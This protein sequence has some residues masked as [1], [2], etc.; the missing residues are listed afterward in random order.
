MDVHNSMLEKGEWGSIE[1]ALDARCA[2]WL[3]SCMHAC[4]VCHTGCS[5]LMCFIAS[6][7]FTQNG[8]NVL[9]CLTAASSVQLVHGRLRANSAEF[10]EVLTLLICSLQ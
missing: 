4:M 3:R 2:S 9:S 8:M 5:S 6:E 10:H 7:D 1:T